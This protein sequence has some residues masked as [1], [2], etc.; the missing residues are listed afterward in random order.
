MLH[1]QVISSTPHFFAHGPLT[2]VTTLTRL[3]AL[4]LKLHILYG[5]VQR[6][7][8]GMDILFTATLFTY[9]LLF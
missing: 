6:F 2:I 8:Q 9:C 3:F 7:I 4:T 5:F 1:K